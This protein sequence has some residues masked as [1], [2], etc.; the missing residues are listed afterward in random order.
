[1]RYFPFTFQV[2]CS[3]SGFRLTTLEVLHSLMT[4]GYLNG[5]C[6]AKHFNKCE[7]FSSRLTDEI[8]R[9]TKRI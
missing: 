5:Q 6:T 8:K 3:S 1:M 9:N 7:N 2:Q 4:S